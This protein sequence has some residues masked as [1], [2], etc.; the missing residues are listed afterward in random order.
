[1]IWQLGERAMQVG[2]PRAHLPQLPLRL[3]AQLPR[4]PRLPLP[5]QR[6]QTRVGERAGDG[7]MLAMLLNDFIKMCNCP[8]ACTYVLPAL[9]GGCAAPLACDIRCS[10]CWCACA[11][12]SGLHAR[13]LHQP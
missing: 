12:G 8:C 4:P 5:L 3:L 9:P 13:E 10:G 11:C 7:D 2:P 6:R 1:M